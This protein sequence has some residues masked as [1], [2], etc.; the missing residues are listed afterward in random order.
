MAHEKLWSVENL[1]IIFLDLTE[2]SVLLAGSRQDNGDP[3]GLWRGK[4]KESAGFH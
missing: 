1:Y 3:Q 4:S 2:E